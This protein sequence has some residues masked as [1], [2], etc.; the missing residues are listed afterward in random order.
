M[1]FPRI[2]S[3]LLQAIVPAVMIVLVSDPAGLLAQS[4]STD[5]IVSSQT[6]Q[7][8]VESSSAARQKNVD[9]LTRFM[10]TPTAEKAM[11]DAKI[12]PVQVQ[13]AIPTLS[14]SEL[15]NLSSRASDAQQK[16]SAG[17]LGSSTLTL[18][19]VLVAVIIIVAIIH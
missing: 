1:K 10:S 8:Q 5:H 16:F 14:D 4:T 12:D 11:R 15:A 2:S 7:K 9:A 18:I 3:L 19:I 17:V 13:K 6:L